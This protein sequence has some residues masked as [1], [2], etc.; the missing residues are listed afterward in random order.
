MRILIDGR[1][2]CHN[3]A[4]ITSF[5]TG[6]LI[7]WACQQEQDKF[8]VF[9]PKGI[10]PSIEL[11]VLPANVHLL[12]Y[13]RHCPSFLPN[14]IIL[15]L[16]VPIICRRL[17]IDLYYTPVT[18]LPVCLPIHVKTLVTVHDV[19]NVEMA[20]TMAFTNRLAMSL[21]FSSAVKNADYLWANSHYTK[22]KIEQYFPKRKCQR[23]FVGGAVDTDTYFRR[24]LNENQKT[25]IRHKYGIDGR[26][27]LFVGS[28]EPRK[29][30]PF[31][32]QIMPEMYTKHGIQLV[33]VGGKGWKNSSIRETIDNPSFPKN[34]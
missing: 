16:L 15:Q 17:K 28:L 2:W 23:I 1:V 5:L 22:G 3:A 27:L 10:D 13:S 21:F 24:H 7:E 6:S 9:L 25:E 18:H 8:F 33:V 30:L 19:V 11:P 32:L 26:F 14:I 31:L 20:H 29:N 34:P 12:D 4:G